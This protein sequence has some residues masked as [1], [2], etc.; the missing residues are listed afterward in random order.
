MTLLLSLVAAF[1][2]GLRV[3]SGVPM[4]NDQGY[5]FPF[6]DLTDVDVTRIE[7]LVQLQIVARHGA[8]SGNI[9]ISEIFPRV[10][11]S[12]PGADWTCNFTQITSRV[13]DDEEFMAFQ[14]NYIE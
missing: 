14:K 7:R 1:S 12:K 3:Q 9:P 8:R 5:M 11:L 13:Y 2:F 4:C 6:A 10:N